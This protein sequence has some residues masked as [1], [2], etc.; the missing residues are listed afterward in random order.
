MPD[1]SSATAG[2]I[3]FDH[4]HLFGCRGGCELPI[5]DCR[6]AVS[7]ALDAL[8]KEIEGLRNPYRNHGGVG[9]GNAYGSGW[10]EALAAVLAKIEE[11]RR[12]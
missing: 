2:P 9:Q 5:H 12:V 4:G 1:W 11:A 8:A 10:E 7:A 6:E 3:T